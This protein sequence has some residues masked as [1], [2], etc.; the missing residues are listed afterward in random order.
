M[1]AKLKRSV[2]RM[3]HRNGVVAV[4]ENVRSQKSHGRRRTWHRNGKLASEEFYRDGLLHGVFRQWNESGVLLGSYKM[5]RGTGIQREWHDNGRLNL[6]FSTV[7]GGFF[8]RSRQW[9]QDGTLLSDQI[10]LE[11]RIVTPDEYRKVAKQNPNLPKLRGRIT[12]SK[13]PTS[14]HIHHVFVSSLLAKRNCCEAR[15][16]LNADDN[17][18]RSLGRFKR[19]SDTAKFIEQLYQAGAGKVIVPEIY[20]GKGGKQFA[21]A[22]LLQ[23]PRSAKERKAIRKACDKLRSQHLG[24]VEPE[25]DIGETHLFLSMA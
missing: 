12:K 13:R 19:T 7:N 20:F 10:Y 5:E 8:G 15:T 14:K 21:D 22:L 11:G 3:F 17:T 9:L 25:K 23:L 4:E 16:W 18:T 2:R 24:A 6:E 1:S